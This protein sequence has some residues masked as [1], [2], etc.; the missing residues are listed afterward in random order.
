MPD[1]PKSVHMTMTW[2]RTVMR[3][4]TPERIWPDMRPEGRKSAVLLF[5]G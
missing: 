4:E 2:L 5:A 1:A 3:G